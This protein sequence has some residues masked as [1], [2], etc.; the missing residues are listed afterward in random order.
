MY[1]CNSRINIYISQFST[2]FQLLLPNFFQINP[3]IDS[4]QNIFT[5]NSIKFLHTRKGFPWRIFL[6]FL[7]KTRVNFIRYRSTSFIYLFFFLFLS[8]KITVEILNWSKYKSQVEKHLLCSF[9]RAWERTTPL[10]FE[11]QSRVLS[12]DQRARR[13]PF[14]KR[15]LSL[16]FTPLEFSR[17]TS[18]HRRFWDHNRPSINDDKRTNCLF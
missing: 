11:I 18:D 15:I 13:I 17:A 10:F 14:L 2:S 12:L 6:T 4:Q 9:K 7:F 8:Q 3:F 16:S 5:N 1:S